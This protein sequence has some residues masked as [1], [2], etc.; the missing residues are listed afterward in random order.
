MFSGL[1]WGVRFFIAVPRVARDDKVHYSSAPL[2]A[3]RLRKTGCAMCPQSTVH[4]F[5]PSASDASGVF[6]HGCSH[7][8]LRDFFSRFTPLNSPC[9]VSTGPP[10][11]GC[12]SSWRTD[13]LVCK[14]VNGFRQKLHYCTPVWWG[15][16]QGRP[17]T[18][19]LP[20]LYC[21]SPYY[22]YYYCLY[23]CTAKILKNIN[24]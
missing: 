11:V 7:L 6:P 17:Y 8:R 14:E 22:Y 24:E 10:I 16:V 9:S 15:P 2:A 12:S 3:V 23:S 1:S 18:V 19:A 21:L 5:S 20:L 4:G 13:G